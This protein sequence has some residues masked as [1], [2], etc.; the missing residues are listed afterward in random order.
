MTT[1][2]T[3]RPVPKAAPKPTYQY[4]PP[5]YL[6]EII[7]KADTDTIDVV[8]WFETIGDGSFWSYVG[9]DSEGKVLFSNH[10]DGMYVQEEG[11]SRWTQVVDGLPELFSHLDQHEQSRIYVNNRK[12]R[13]IFLASMEGTSITVVNSASVGLINLTQDYWDESHKKYLV[14]KNIIVTTDGAIKG[15]FTGIGWLM[16]YEKK[17]ITVKG[18]AKDIYLPRGC[19]NPLNAE[20]KAIEYS[21][22]N[23]TQLLKYELLERGDELTV[24]SDSLTSIVLINHILNGE[25]FGQTDPFTIALAESICNKV[26][27]LNVKFVWVKGHNGDLMNEA[28]D[29]LAVSARRNKQY[30][31]SEEVAALV[32]RNI[33]HDVQVELNESGFILNP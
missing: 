30:G 15:D 20:L 4:E 7:H 13:E 9:T 5:T 23:V 16:V 1:T 12:L 21:L 31:V 32:T 26:R 28:C 27:N 14:R 8:F 10:G 11:A 17:N 3:T 29:R 22:R 6:D 25:K 33:I 19:R 24:R 2:T 18:S